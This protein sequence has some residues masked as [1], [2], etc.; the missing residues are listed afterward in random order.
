MSKIHLWYISNVES[1]GMKKYSD[2][3]NSQFQNDRVIV[4]HCLYNSTINKLNKPF[5]GKNLTV[6]KGKAVT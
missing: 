3:R 2:M 1:C 5:W 6:A 4:G